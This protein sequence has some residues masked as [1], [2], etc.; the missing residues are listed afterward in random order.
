MI[1]S[2]R[3][4][5]KCS[6]CESQ[7]SAFGFDPKNPPRVWILRIHDPFLILPPPLKKKPVLG[8]SPKKSILKKFPPWRAE[9]SSCGFVCRIHRMRVDGRH[10]FLV[11]A[12]VGAAGVSDLD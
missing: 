2:N 1:F 7:K 10:I 5:K 9:S 8:L 4:P 11:L 3:F 6:D 12:L